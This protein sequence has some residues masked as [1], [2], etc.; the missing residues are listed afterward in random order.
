MPPDAIGRLSNLE[1]FALT[2]SKVSGTIPSEFGKLSN[3]KYFF[4]VS[5]FQGIYPEKNGTRPRTSHTTSLIVV[6][7]FR[8]PGIFQ[9]LFPVRLATC[10]CSVS[11]EIFM[12]SCLFLRQKVPN[13]NS[14]FFLVVAEDLAFTMTNV[15]GTIPDNI[16]EK[17]KNGALNL[18]AIPVSADCPCCLAPNNSSKV[19]GN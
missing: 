7:N 11:R 4:I 17:Q 9:D 5:T 1:F 16:C 19:F 12:R 10:R 3:L 15:N 6:L 14:S 18:G 8:R 13:E 2:K